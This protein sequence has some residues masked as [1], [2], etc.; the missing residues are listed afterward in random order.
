MA[1]ISKIHG[2]II[3]IDNKKIFPFFH[4]AYAIYNPK[5]FE[6]MKSDFLK[7]KELLC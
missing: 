7:L 6:I 3:K 2:R 4:P 5:K 1:E